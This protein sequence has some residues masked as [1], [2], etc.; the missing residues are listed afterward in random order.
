MKTTPTVTV[1]FRTLKIRIKPDI[2]LVSFL[3]QHIGATRF[4]FNNCIAYWERLYVDYQATKKSFIPSAYDLRTWA[5]NQ[6]ASMILD[7]ETWLKETNSDV[8]M[9]GAFRAH[10]AI[11]RFV[12]GQSKFPKF[13]D[14]YRGN[15]A[16]WNKNLHIRDG[17]LYL[18]RTSINVIWHKNLPKDARIVSVTIRKQANGHFYASIYYETKTAPKN[19]GTP[20]M[21]WDSSVGVD[22]GLTT[23]ATLSDG[24]TFKNPK[25]LKKALKK[26]K[27]QQ[28]HLKRCQKGSN[29]RRKVGR[30]VAKIHSKVANTR[31]YCHKQLAW[32]LARNYGYICLEKLDIKGMLQNRRYARSVSDAAFGLI[33][34]EI[35]KAAAKYGRKVFLADTF[36]PSSKTCSHCGNINVELSIKDRTWECSHCHTVHKRDV[37]AAIMLRKDGL[38]NRL[39]S[40][41]SN[42]AEDT[43]KKGA[44]M[45]CSIR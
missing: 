9:E 3:T 5:R 23:L 21:G 2:V 14:K 17:I 10:D 18:G 38:R 16:K 32:F 22:L 36:F 39:G 6:R 12:N 37:N 4:I 41:R 30:K 31:K 42:D 29:R 19:I 34:T 40:N 20:L 7:G 43:S 28:R 35:E 11:K 45:L 1:N 15:T 25:P 44:A 27:R 24:T 8:I 13:K 26:L 33:R